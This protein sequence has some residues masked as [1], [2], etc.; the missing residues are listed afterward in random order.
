VS[1]QISGENKDDSWRN[2][3]QSLIVIERWSSMLDSPQNC[4][5]PGAVKRTTNFEI[6]QT[7]MIYYSCNDNLKWMKSNLCPTT[8]VFSSTLRLSVMNFSLKNKKR[9]M[10]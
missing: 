1:L 8:I 6:N 10:S 3:M 9:E 5:R 2:K 4:L 7:I